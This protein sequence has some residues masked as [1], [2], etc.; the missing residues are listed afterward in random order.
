M[1]NK[2]RFAPPRVISENDQPVHIPPNTRNTYVNHLSIKRMLILFSALF[3]I[4]AFSIFAYT[5]DGYIGD[6]YPTYIY[7]DLPEYGFDE[8]YLGDYGYGYNT[9]PYE[10]YI[11]Y[12]QLAPTIFAK[13]QTA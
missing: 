10:S 1:N 9:Y 4:S 8:Y 2:F 11:S 6:C 3:L 7:Y 5:Y 12:I 13:Q